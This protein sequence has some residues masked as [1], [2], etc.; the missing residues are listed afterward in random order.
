MGKTAKTLGGMMAPTKVPIKMPLMPASAPSQA[1]MVSRG[2]RTSASPMMVK[3]AMS[4]GA[5]LNRVRPLAYSPACSEPS[6]RQ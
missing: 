3:T 6:C 1:A 4:S 2:M 5:R